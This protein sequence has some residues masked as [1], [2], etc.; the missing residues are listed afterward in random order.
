MCPGSLVFKKPGGP[1]DMRD[2]RNWWKYVLGAD[3][4]HP[5]GPNST[6]R[7]RSNFPVV[8]VA[9]ADAEAY[10]RWSGK[11]LPSEAEWE[12]AGP[13]PGATLLVAARARVRVAVVGRYTS[14]KGPGIVRRRDVRVLGNEPGQLAVIAGIQPF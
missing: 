13:Q 3:W 5:V 2:F 6:I 10:A 8:H 4:R 1:V 7:G 9:Y 14:Q 11:S 12:F